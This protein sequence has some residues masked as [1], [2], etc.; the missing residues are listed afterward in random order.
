MQ[1]KRLT[2]LAACLFLLS[3]SAKAQQPPPP[4]SPRPGDAIKGILDLS[5]QQL[6]QLTDLR[7]SFQQKMRGFGD[8]LR[9]LEQ[10]KRELLQSTNPDATALGN[11]LIQEQGLHRQ[12]QDANKSYHDSAL[13]LERLFG[14]S[15]VRDEESCEFGRNLLGGVLSRLAEIDAVIERTAPLWPSDQLAPVDR[16]ILRLAIRESMVDNL[17]PV[18]AAIN[19]AVE[20]AKKYGSE[21]SGRFINGVLGSVSAAKAAAQEGN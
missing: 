12:L 20:L 21:N 19:E 4:N 17:T 16:N 18:G 1:F 11:L 5:D 2:I 10:K 3:V 8:Q 15:R 6:Q 14:E 7:N 9:T 13:A